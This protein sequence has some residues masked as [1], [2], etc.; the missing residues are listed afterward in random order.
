[1]STLRRF[2]S[3]LPWLL[4]VGAAQA[5]DFC[6]REARVDPEL[7]AGF[8]GHYRIAG[9]TAEG[10]AYAGTLA[11]AAGDTHYTLERRVDSRTVRGQAWFERCGAD[12]ILQLF[13]RIDARPALTLACASA[14]DSENY[15]RV[16]CTGRRGERGVQPLEAW[17]QQ[18]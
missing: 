18:P 14:V 2:V 1:M 3:V 16:T 11:V 17:F 15:Y 8:A 10:S 6:Q 7:P 4:A 9:I 12:R 13:V 5:G